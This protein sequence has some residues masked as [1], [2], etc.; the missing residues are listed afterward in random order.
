MRLEGSG[1]RRLLKRLRPSQEFTSSFFASLWYL[2]K[3]F[4]VFNLAVVS[5]SGRL[6]I[7]F[8][9]SERILRAGMAFREIKQGVGYKKYNVPIGQ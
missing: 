2:T 4:T 7:Y 1:E 8:T 6:L 5:I 9:H 3:H